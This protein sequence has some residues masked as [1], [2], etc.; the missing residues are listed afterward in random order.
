MCAVQGGHLELIK[1]ALANGC[2]WSAGASQEAAKFGQI[3]IL[4]WA[5][6]K[7]YSVDSSTCAAAAYGNQ[8]DLLV[9]LREEAHCDWDVKTTATAANR[10]CFDILMYAVDAG[11]PAPWQPPCM[12]TT[13]LT[14]TQHNITQ[15]H[16][17]THY[18]QQNKQPTR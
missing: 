3:E 4:Q 15:Q 5:V 8:F 18:K 16:N 7:G 6:S 1:W 2:D 13:N 12:L 14:T 11:C 9:W 17:T 10:G